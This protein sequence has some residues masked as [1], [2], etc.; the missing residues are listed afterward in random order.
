[1]GAVIVLAVTVF[2]HFLAS[3]TSY[4]CLL[5]CLSGV[6]FRFW[7]LWLQACSRRFRL[8]IATFLYQVEPRKHQSVLTFIS[9]VNRHHGILNATNSLLEFVSQGRPILTNWPTLWGQG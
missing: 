6:C 5:W 9:N 1:M 3:A 8:F 2:G 7:S 4:G